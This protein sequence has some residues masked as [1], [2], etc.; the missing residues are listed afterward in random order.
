M[1]MVFI[2]KKIING[3]ERYYLEESI[4]LPKGKVK[5]YSLYLRDYNPGKKYSI[6]DYK[7]KLKEKIKEHLRETAL[8]HYKKD[9][10]F[11]EALIKRLEDTKL[12]WKEIKNKLTKNQL[13][14]IIDRFT[15]NFTYESNALEG[16]SLTLK[17]VTIVLKEKKALKNKDLRE[18]YET[19]NTRKAMELIFNN[20]LRITKK[21][22][23]KLHKILVQNTGVSSGYKQLP[24]FL[25]DRDVETTKPENVEKEMENLIRWY[26]KNENIH[27]LQRASIF[28][29]RLEKIHPFE[30]GNGRVG[31]LLI[32]VMLINNGYIPIIIRKNQRIAYFNCLE[33][34]DKGYKDRLIRFIIEKYKRTYDRF[35]E[36]YMKYLKPSIKVKI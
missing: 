3:K 32:N 6:E 18:I 5:K 36:V 21:D 31:R 29:G 24:N 33:A 1:Y 19:L 34:F 4:R 20:K 2:S 9:Y 10:L 13:K 12:D 17:D 11:D 8:K 27:P 26:H 35:F 15:I 22:I 30:D 14:D 23:I 25:L 7:I 16:N 28:H